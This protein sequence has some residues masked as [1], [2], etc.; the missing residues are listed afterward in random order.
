MEG[1]KR[2]ADPGCSA[3]SEVRV[4]QLG[5]VLLKGGVQLGKLRLR[6]QEE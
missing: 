2:L 5:G 3:A 1:A 4:A 6:G